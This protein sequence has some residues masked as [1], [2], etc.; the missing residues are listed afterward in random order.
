M[1]VKMIHFVHDHSLYNHSNYSNAW[2]YINKGPDFTL[3][4]GESVIIMFCHGMPL[5]HRISE[6]ACAL[7]ARVTPEGVLFMG[8]MITNILH[9]VT[10]TVLHGAQLPDFITSNTSNHVY[11]ELCFVRE[12][13]YYTFVR[14]FIPPPPPTTP[15]VEHYEEEEEEE[16]GRPVH[17]HA[18][19][20]P[21]ANL[22]I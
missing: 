3:G 13:D 14:E 12:A 8:Q 17:M 10:I 22:Q 18:L 5:N 9:N 1:V 21:F 16:Q 4:T 2:N 20:C 15:M 11:S 7:N 6:S 19:D